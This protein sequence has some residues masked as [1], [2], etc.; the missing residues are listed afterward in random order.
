MND[1]PNGQDRE[2]NRPGIL[3]VFVLSP[4]SLHD[5]I[6]SSFLESAHL[7]RATYAPRRFLSEIGCHFLG[8]IAT[9]W[10]LYPVDGLRTT[11]RLLLRTVEV[12]SKQQRRATFLSHTHT[13]IVVHSLYFQPSNTHP[14]YS[15]LLSIGIN[16]T[17]DYPPR[18]KPVVAMHR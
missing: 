16:R 9:E 8:K 5:Q 18:A 15:L 4:C 10:R 3:A 6:S 14:T 12:N 2:E 13:Y 7:V 17:H 1:S 11:T